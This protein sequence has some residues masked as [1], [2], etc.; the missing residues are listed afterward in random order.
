MKVHYTAEPIWFLCLVYQELLN[1][2]VC[3]LTL[4]SNNLFL[5]NTFTFGV[6]FTIQHTKY[7]SSD[8]LNQAE[9]PCECARIHLLLQDTRH[10]QQ[11]SL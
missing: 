6:L 10:L 9:S 4:K 11:T 2:K 5:G 1:L 8:V 7:K 3:T